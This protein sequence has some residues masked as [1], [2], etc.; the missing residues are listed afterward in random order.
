M[1]FIES[2]KFFG[3]KPGYFGLLQFEMG[4]LHSGSDPGYNL[5]PIFQLLLY[6]N[7]LFLTPALAKKKRSQQ[8]HVSYLSFIFLKFYLPIFLFPL[9]QG[10]R[11]CY[12]FVW[13][14][15]QHL[16]RDNWI[17]H[18]ATFQPACIGSKQPLCSLSLAHTDTHCSSIRLQGV[19]FEGSDIFYW[20][21]WCDKWTKDG[22]CARIEV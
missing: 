13:C 1:F 17:T 11:P 21:E 5:S 9:S 20:Y 19:R 16:H 8:T 10:F 2:Y 15:L 4:L 12:Q 18:Q 6:A 7:T 3:S 14:D 22:Y